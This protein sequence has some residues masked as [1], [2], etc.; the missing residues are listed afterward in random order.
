M[1]LFFCDYIST[2]LFYLSTVNNIIYTRRAEMASDRYWRLLPETLLSAASMVEFVVLDC[3][4]ADG[5]MASSSVS[6]RRASSGGGGKRASGRGR[7]G[8]G[9]VAGTGGEVALW[10]AVVSFCDGKPGC[11]PLDPIDM[12]G[13]TVGISS[14][15]CG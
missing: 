11:C 7:G 5:G 6:Q 3:E 8:G 9:K 1:P 10:E 12:R 13:E 14:Y 15:G 2:T 4:P